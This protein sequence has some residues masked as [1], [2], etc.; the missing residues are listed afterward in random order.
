M[1][2]ENPVKMI[3]DRLRGKKKKESGPSIS[4]KEFLKI[5]PVRNPYL[6]WEK[7]KKGEIILLIPLNKEKQG[8]IG[9]IAKTPKE[10]K[11]EL[12]KIGS[13][14]WELCDGKRTVKD[15]T[16]IL[17]E[18]YKLLLSEAEISLNTYFNS[19][20]KRGLMGFVLPEETRARF[21]EPS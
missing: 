17:R 8:F 14:V 16:E 18:R 12:D 19:L 6:K 4:R 11:I 1:I 21:Q 10:K 3:L 7:D 9:K 5:K 13:I 15:I 20:S 2:L